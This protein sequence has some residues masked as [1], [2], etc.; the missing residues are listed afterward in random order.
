MIMNP[1]VADVFRLR[2][3]ITSQIRRHMEELGYLEIETPILQGAA[4]G[5]EARPFVTYHNTLER[6]LFLRIATELHLKRM[7]VGGFEKVFEIGR[8]FRNEGISARHNPEF[9][10]VEMYQAY[11]DYH[12][13]MEIAEDIIIRCAMATHGRLKLQYQGTE[14][15]LEKPW[16]RATMKVLVEEATGIDFSKF[17]DLN[18][19]KNAALSALSTNNEGLETSS[20]VNCLS[21]GHLLNEIFELV[22]ERTLIQPTFVTDYPVEISPLAKPHRSCAGLVER[23]ELFVCGRELANAFS[24]LTDP[25]EQR[26]RFQSQ[27]QVHNDRLLIAAEDAEKKGDSDPKEN[28]DAYEVKLDEDFITALE[29]GMP[30][31]AGMGMGVDRLVM[32]LTD[33]AS[34]RDVIAFPVLK[35]Q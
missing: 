34:I 10:S 1:E 21:F 7:M 3:K 2:A 26:V 18:A 29:Y 8:I 31:A 24:E 25:V 12:A 6:D 14:I 22:V 28:N 19:A 13:M 17:N 20:I 27:I 15:V 16:R 4:G 5:A 33:T 30:P 11:A 35:S 23:F 9:T 32:L